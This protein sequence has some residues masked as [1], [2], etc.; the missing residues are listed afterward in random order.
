MISKKVHY[1][2]V[3]KVRL[4]CQN[5]HSVLHRMRRVVL[6]PQTGHLF[7]CEDCQVEYDHKHSKCLHS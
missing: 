4:I 2:E 1:A 7:C 3:I 5:C 6:N